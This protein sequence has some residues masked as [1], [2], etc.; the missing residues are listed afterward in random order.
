MQETPQMGQGVVV[1][2][3]TLSAPAQGAANDVAQ[4]QTSV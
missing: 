2:A 3:K 1:E 4:G